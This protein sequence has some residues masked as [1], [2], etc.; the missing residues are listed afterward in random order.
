LIRPLTLRPHPP[1]VGFGRS[2]CLNLNR[3]KAREYYKFRLRVPALPGI[4]ATA[5]LL[6]I[7]YTSYNGFAPVCQAL[8]DEYRR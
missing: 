4:A 8:I 2:V 6:T 1:E 3:P 5:L 7:P